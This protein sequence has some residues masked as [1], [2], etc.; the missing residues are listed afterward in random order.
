MVSSLPSSLSV[1]SAVNIKVR[2]LLSQLFPNHRRRVSVKAGERR[3]RTRKWD[4]NWTSPVIDI[5]VIRSGNNRSKLDN[6]SSLCATVY[7]SKRHTNNESDDGDNVDDSDSSMSCESITSPL[8]NIDVGGWLDVS[9]T[10]EC[11]AGRGSD[12]HVSFSFTVNGQVVG[13]VPLPPFAFF[14]IGGVFTFGVVLACLVVGDDGGGGGEC[15]TARLR[16]EF[17]SSCPDPKELAG[18]VA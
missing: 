16:R 9:A 3:R 12:G 4:D 17:Y 18:A 6:C 2:V 15:L 14:S 13:K 5:S 1:C 8:S 10:I 7:F 11:G